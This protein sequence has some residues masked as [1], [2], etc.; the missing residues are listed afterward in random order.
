M[1][2]WFVKLS[3]K[4]VLSRLPVSGLAWQRLH[5]FRAGVMDNEESARKIF[6]QH[7]NSVGLTDLHGKTILELG[8]GNGLLSGKFA[9]ELGAEKTWLIDAFPLAEPATFPN[10]VYRSEGLKSLK[11]IPSGSV[12]YLF[13][14]A[15]LEHI[16]LKEFPELIFETR[17][18]L[19]PDGLCS[20]QI[21]FRDHLGGALN[22][23]RFSEQRWESDFMS[24]SG[25]YTN[26]IPWSRMCQI[27]AGEG[28][29][30]TTIKRDVWPALPTPQRAMA[31]PYQEMNAQ[32]LLTWGCHVVL[33][34][35]LPRR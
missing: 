9:N 18:I 30:I 21:D 7:L 31:E 8:P 19:K 1:I 13:S 33:R 35:A 6:F 27:I 3:G 16:R 4:I 17:R 5:L 10:T 20:H 23:L 32:D 28:F 24:S 14:N 26:R 11:E 12:D 15:V 22:N 34:K 25:F 29:A 2:P